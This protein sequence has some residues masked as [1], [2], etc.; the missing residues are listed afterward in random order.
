MN[1]QAIR[2]AYNLFVSTG[3]KKSYDEFKQLMSSNP[4]ALQDA[5]GLFV[6]TGYKKDINAFK[7]LMGADGQIAQPVQ[8]DVKKKE[9][10]GVMD[11]VQG[12]MSGT[13]ESQSAGSSLASQSLPTPSIEDLRSIKL[14]AP[15][16]TTQV[17][18]GI[19]READFIATQKK[20]LEEQENAPEFYKSSLNTITGDFIDRTEE[21]VV[22]QMNYQF[23]PMGFKFEESGAT[24]DWMIATAPN[25]QTKEFSL[26]PA[27]GIGAE[28]TAEEIRNWIKENTQMSGL[29]RLESQYKDANRKFQNQEEIDSEY[30]KLNE[31]AEKFKNETGT[32]LNE[33]TY[34]ENELKNLNSMRLEERQKPENVA[35]YN[36]LLIKQRELKTT[37]QKLLSQ[38]EQLKSNA[39]VLDNSV[40]KYSLMKA[41]QGEWSTGIWNAITEGVGSMSS[42]AVNLF[43]DAAYSKYT[44]GVSMD[45]MAKNVQAGTSTGNPKEDAKTSLAISNA[46]RVNE[47]RKAELIPMPQA[48]QSYQEWYNSLTEYQKELIVDKSNDDIKKDLKVNLLPAIRQGSRIVYGN[49]D[50][51]VEWSRTKE[52]GFWGGAILGVAKSLPA[53]VGS[54]TVLGWAQRTAQM[55]GQTS[56]AVYEEMSKNPEFDNISESEKL[57][58]VAPI[59]IASA[60]LESI[61][62]RNIVANKGLMNRI[63]LGAMGKAGATTTAK[64]FGELVKNEVASMG[65]RAGLTL[66]GAGLAEAETGA[67]QQAVEYAVKD[68]YNMAKGKDMF[69]TPDFMSADYIKDI[70]KAGAQEAVGGFVLGVP[71]AIGAAYTQKGYKSLSNAQFEAFEAIAND[72]KVQE[73][74]IIRLKEQVGTGLITAKEG[75]EK[76]NY[77]RNAV[78]LYRNIPEGLTIDGKKEAMNLLKE[79][80][81]L[82]QQIQGKDEAL[83]KKQKARIEEINGELDNLTNQPEATP[84]APSMEA[85]SGNKIQVLTEEEDKRKTSL[86]EAI[87]RAT[88]TA[89]EGVSPLAVSIG[90]DLIAFEDAQKE[91]DALNEKVNTAIAEEQRQRQ[92]EGPSVLATPEATTSALESLPTDERTN[93]TFTQEDGTETPV[94]GNEQMLSDLFHQAQST[95]EENRTD[96]QQSVLDAV[97]VSLKTQI[98][99]EMETKTLEQMVAEEEQGDWV[100]NTQNEELYTFRETSLDAV[101][102]QFR[103][104]VKEVEPV[105]ATVRKRFLGLPIGKKE[106]VELA[107]KLYQYTISGGDI[108]ANK[109]VLLPKRNT[110]V[111]STA[112]DFR[113]EQ[114]PDKGSSNVRN[115]ADEYIALRR[116]ESKKN[117]FRTRTKT[118]LITKLLPSVSKMIASAYEDVKN[119]PNDERVK[120]AYDAM[121]RETLQQYDFI[122]S[123]GLKA[124]RYEGKGEPYK[125][126]QEMIDDIKNNNH[127]YFLPNDEAFG[128][129][130]K[131]AEGNIGLQKSGRKLSDGYELTNSE[132]FRIVHD[133][134]GHGS[135]GNEFGAI[136]EENAALQHVAMYSNEAIPAVVYQTRG[137][138][139]WVNFSGQ[140]EE[141]KKLFQEAKRL[142]QEGKT[143]E[144]DK[145]SEEGRKKFKFAEPKI[146]LFPNL[147][148]F[149][150]YES[151]RRLEEQQAINE[152]GD[153]TDSEVSSTLSSIPDKVRTERGVSKSSV[154]ETKRIRGNDVEVIATY[155]LANPILN[156]IK[157]IFP[158]FVSL[159]KIYEI[160]DG[161]L[162]RELMMDALKDNAFK[163]SVT[164]HSAEDFGNMR[165][166]ITEDGSTGITLTKDGFLGGAF[167]D[168]NSKRPNN[169]A[170]LMI[171]GIKEGATTAEAFDT[172]LPDY[173]AMY[174]FKAVSRTAFNDEFRPL[175]E[176]GALE[177]WDYQKYGAF[178]DGRPDVVFMIYDGGNRATIEDRIGQFDL[179]N[180]YEKENTE[181]FDKDNYDAAYSV[182]NKEAVKRFLYEQENPKQETQG[183]SLSEAASRLSEGDLENAQKLIDRL[184]KAFP[185]VKIYV[186]KP[187][188]DNVMASDKVRKYVKDGMVIYGVTVDGDIYINPDIHDSASALFNTSIHEFGHVWSNFL[189][190]TARGKELYTKGVAL[191]EQ[192]AKTDEKIKAMYAEQLKKFDGDKKRALN[193]M[194]S[195]LIG[196]KGADFVNQTLAGRFK[197]W[198]KAVF[199]FI[200]SEF[201][202]SRDLTSEQIQDMTLDQFIGTALAD[203]FSGQRLTT[204]KAQEQQLKNPEVAFSARQSPESIIKMG[205]AN[206]F[207]EESIK[208]VLRGRGLTE[209]EITKAMA[210]EMGS[211]TRIKLSEEFLEGFDSMMAEVNAIIEKMK[212]DGADKKVI[213]ESVMDS[214]RKTEAYKNANDVQLNQL[215]RDI[216]KMLEIRQKSSPSLGRDVLMGLGRVILGDIV[217]VKK[218]TMTEKELF[219][220]QI[221][222]LARGAKN[223]KIA[224]MK[225]SSQLAK[226]IKE[227]ALKGQLTNRQVA[228]IIRRFASVNMFNEDSIDKFVDYMTNVFED[229]N[230]DKKVDDARKKLKTARTNIRTKIGVSEAA[231]PI[232][233]RLFSINPTLIPDAVFNKY[234]ALVDMFGAKGAVLT[235]T[236]VNDVVS[237]ANEILDAVNEEVSL[238]EEL[239]IRFEEYEDKVFDEDGKLDYAKTIA[240]M[241]EEEA[242]NEQELE[243]MKKYK[244]IILPRVKKP[245]MTEQEIQNEK[246]RIINGIQSLSVDSDRLPTRME[247]DLANRFKK[248]LNPRLLNRMS[249]AQLNNIAKLIDNINN[250]YLPHYAQLTVERLNAIQRAETLRTAIENA[251]P[252][253]FSKRYAAFKSMFTGKGATLEMIRRS[254][255]FFIDQ[256]FGDFKTK[257]IFNAVFEQVAEGHAAFE[258]SMNR[259]NKK[260]DAAH[261]AVAK[262]YK[263]KVNE[264]LNSSFKM[265]T[266]LVQLEY[267]TNPE[268]NQ[269]NSAAD[270]IRATVKHI[271]KGKSK[272]KERDAEMLENI[273][274]EYGVVVGQDKNGKDIIEIDKNEL[275]NSFN[276]AEVNAIETIREINDGMRDMAVYTAAVIRG[277]RIEP[278]N[279]YIHLPVMHDYKPDERATGTQSAD[280]YNNSLRPST[281]AQSL[282]AR[283][284][285][286][287]PINFDAFAS[288]QRGAKF[289]NLDYYMTEPV[290]TARKTLNETEIMM[291]EQGR[292]PKEQREVFNAINQ[293]FEE[294]VQNVLTNNFITDSFADEVVNF[295]SK[296]GYR[297]I[298]ASTTRFVAELA[299]N[300][301]FVTVTDPKAFAEGVKY[302]SI[303]MSP[304][305]VNVMD[306]VGSKQTTRLFQKD[307]LGGRFVD[308]S[309]MSQASG[310]RSTTSKS[311]VA[312][313]TNMIYNLSLKKYKNLVEIV[314]DGLISTPDKVVMRPVWFGSFATEFKNQTGQEVDFNKIAENDEAYMAQHKE[315]I[316]KARDKADERSVLT[317]A[318]DNPF[319][320]I[321]KGTTKPNQSALTRGFNNFNNFMTRFAIYEYTTARQGIYAAMGNGS[322]TRKQGAAMLA[323]VTIRMTS[324]TLLSTLL[325]NGLVGLVSDEEEP[326]DEKSFMQKFG[327][328]LASTGVGLILGRDFGN[329]SKSLI[330]YGVE[331]MNEEFLTELR[332]GDYDPYKDAISYSIIPKEKKGHKTNLTDFITQM[333]G[334]F[335]P[336]L[337][338]ADL[339]ARKAFESPKKEE[340]AIER[341][342]KETQI[343]IPLEVLGNLGYIPLY[344][345]I[346]RV[347]MSELYKELENAPKEAAK[348]KADAK[349]KLHGYENKTD[350]KRY[351]PDLYEQE[352]GAASPEYE[353]EQAEKKIEKEK[354]ILERKMKDD[355]YDY[356]P[357]QE[358]NSGFGSKPFGGGTTKKKK[359][360][361]GFG[362]GST[363]GSKG[364]GK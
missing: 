231:A 124:E 152:R 362:S 289:V 309:I 185:S 141:A 283:T 350:L 205:R 68:I 216:E 104:R 103:D 305:S 240:Q 157:A 246:N 196:N 32:F 256:V 268:S 336:A 200:K 208:K 160:T 111:S 172:I 133:Y 52:E 49:D 122:V 176:N 355:L 167:S 197:N 64:T 117:D 22:P 211:A 299:S 272:Y 100:D 74:Y 228:S 349:A 206:G 75:K 42:G 6:N 2:D 27:F 119:L 334:S 220:K 18:L 306:N 112:P 279:N 171:L 3:Y 92:A 186:S 335:G 39:T 106:T 165:M 187:M 8:E 324:Y 28:S 269:V 143:E 114:V 356:I 257:Q 91:L 178:N 195:I 286:V 322:I 5:Y 249:I 363:F 137:Q 25:G 340:D 254:P 241:L 169:L 243:L 183:E 36:D 55:Y 259:I 331:E 147:Y 298:L 47:Q 318:T 263:Y 201:K 110:L 24:G 86:E 140:N 188:F 136:G 123:K 101:P 236:E 62:L 225:T 44:G 40:G 230:Y 79:K 90:E 321:L 217:D 77:Y 162:Y 20:F 26:D 17:A 57:A 41:E 218:I 35:K 226:E 89:P 233:N 14:E 150:K 277:E 314:A 87:A 191:I 181:Y 149:L 266:Y 293:A 300:I 229:S 260:L 71:G 215:I 163:S 84:E 276:D 153:V 341:G 180:S 221:K 130:P 261:D 7:T 264:T 307:T 139:S 194:V 95:P 16:E 297:A 239:A 98:D 358:V 351:A 61:G 262:S 247:R 96:W 337:K 310:V 245:E 346:R 248:L 10:Q 66:L 156:K 304:L 338:T 108:K 224:W 339:I 288:A 107:P 204:T 109:E 59:G 99:E 85:P 34:V 212:K 102:E 97:T 173:Y 361:S 56:D 202:L 330:N 360:K 251:K 174:G 327:Q 359:K 258:S 82:E 88:E 78:G 33:K 155:E 158:A 244:N 23:G 292:I 21:A 72:E 154:R 253:S 222:D 281:K 357:K 9:E 316:E 332:E 320:G 210:K 353:A 45:E 131:M 364:F 333:G 70:A 13:M 198:L 54:N 313:V 29:A 73:A 207:S 345:D 151:A 323:G 214:V 175:V 125:N 132:V 105:E 301:G 120:K 60:A 275:F 138:N 145:V 177:D 284:G 308:T 161:A 135:L 50:T 4:Q 237:N 255:L 311:D 317:G 267:D 113:A 209:E 159:Q 142:R 67:A 328:S 315:A 1:E 285:K 179:Y 189:Q 274:E 182:M 192:A 127:L 46:L 48:G 134:F 223:A 43:I 296:Q 69:Q 290:R 53:M 329:A 280:E 37:Y 118:G 184:K 116:N 168:P 312:N 11:Q 148:N 65:G 347:V 287:S 193:E 76:L 234:L 203:I 219:K 144:A 303:I 83:V 190:T 58:V 250:G 238:S 170:Q 115:T 282:I 146:G 319:M 227:L 12:V 294:V 126:S 326:E 63:V 81:D 94:M 80:R 252:L 348:K 265:M 232:L 271:R 291:E 354:E 352:F 121:I 273:L 342:K 270:Y 343:R 164:V 38:E 242:I 128:E 295:F 15:S 213:L 30:A 129:D 344:K 278:L 51:S 302:R 166:F 31:A 93:I 235:L 325:A 199:T 19:P